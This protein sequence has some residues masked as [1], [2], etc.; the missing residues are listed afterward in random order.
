MAKTNS[1]IKK[2][3]LILTAVLLLVG[4]GGNLVRLFQLQ[5]IDAADYKAKAE[6]QQLSD[7]LISADRGTI[8]DCNMN[9]LAESAS[10]WLVFVDPS[11]IENDAQSQ[12]IAEGLGAILKKPNA[13]KIA[14]ILKANKDYQYAKIAGQV[15]YNEKTAIQNF[16]DDNDLYGIVAIDP[17]TK[18]YYP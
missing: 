1:N 9:V 13:K 7:T 18:R 4:F 8:Y 15:E 14:S 16:I 10:A 2:R 5:V 6:A 12:L 3:A 11:R 17:D